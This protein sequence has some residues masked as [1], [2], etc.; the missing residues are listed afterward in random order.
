MNVINCNFHHCQIIFQIRSFTWVGQAD[1]ELVGVTWKFWTWGRLSD[2]DLADSWE[3]SFSQDPVFVQLQS[4]L[5][6][7]QFVNAPFLRPAVFPGTGR[8]LQSLNDVRPGEVIVSVPLSLVISRYGTLGKVYDHQTPS[9][10]LCKQLPEDNWNF[11]FC[12]PTTFDSGR[13]DLR[14]CPT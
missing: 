6:T 11:P 5:R 10:A 7:K 2:T 9:Q 8:G 12:C 1:T 3:C 4:W 13:R 14:Q